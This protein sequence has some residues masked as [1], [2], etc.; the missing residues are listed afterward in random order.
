V[1]L[2]QRSIA[3]ELLEERWESEPS[4]DVGSDPEGGFQS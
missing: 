2:D 1:E 3:L 4:I